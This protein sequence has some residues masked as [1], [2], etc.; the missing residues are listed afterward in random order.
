L[1]ERKSESHWNTDRSYRLK[2]LSF[3]I[4]DGL[5]PTSE[6]VYSKKILNNN[7]VFLTIVRWNI[8]FLHHWSE[9]SM[10]LFRCR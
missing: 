9:I 8:L 2:S 6:S 7:Y 10:Q 4:G 1:D 3:R 5:D